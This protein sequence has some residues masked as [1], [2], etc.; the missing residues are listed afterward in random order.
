MRRWL[1]PALVLC[2]VPTTIYA[3]DGDWLDAGREEED[4]DAGTERASQEVRDQEVRGGE[5]GSFGRRMAEFGI[6]AELHG[7]VSAELKEIPLPWDDDRIATFDLH[8]Q[9]LNFSVDPH[10]RVQVETQLEWEHAGKDFYVPLAQIDI[11]VGQPLIFR[12]GYFITPVGV[13]NEY[14]YPD[15]LRKSASQPLWTREVLPALWS[16]A[17]LQARGKFD[18]AATGNVNYAVFVSNGLKQE[19]PDPE[20]GVTAE[21]GSIRD[22][23]RN[24]RDK[25]NASKAVGGRLGV[26]PV[27][28]LDF[29]LSGY[30]GAYTEDGEQQLGI[31]DADATLRRGPLLVRTEW[32][33]AQQQVSTGDLQKFGGYAMVAVRVHP[34]VEPYA[35][36]EMVDLDAGPAEQKQGGLVGTVLYPLPDALPSLMWKI[37]VIT[38][39]NGDGDSEGQGYSQLSFAF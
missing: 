18:V 6:R 23:R 28:G 24:D 34:V 1:A 2:A 29:G 14:Q 19:D 12:A 35:W 17:G 31:F 7:Y 22:M 33:L 15:F 39:V 9:V 30:T 25:L 5:L 11:E 20:D 3:Q 21:G 36:F 8:H 27:Q 4:S 37:E 16:E 10:E 13:F 26:A 38:L 32:A